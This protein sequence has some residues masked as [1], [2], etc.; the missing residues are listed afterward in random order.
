[1]DGFGALMA[2]QYA[3]RFGNIPLAR[4]CVEKMEAEGMPCAGMLEMVE[5]LWGDIPA[6]QDGWALNIDGTPARA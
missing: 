2:F 6:A 3:Y 1:M 4:T 5:D